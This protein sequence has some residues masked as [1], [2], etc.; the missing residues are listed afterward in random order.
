MVYSK[1]NKSVPAVSA[2]IL[3]DV[4]LLTTASLYSVTTMRVLYTPLITR[5]DIS[6]VTF[7]VHTPQT[8]AD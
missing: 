7:H 4:L 2:N 3:L 8:C 5:I 6:A 1:Q